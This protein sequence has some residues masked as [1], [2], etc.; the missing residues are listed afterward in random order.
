M[1]RPKHNAIS[2]GW[3]GSLHS[4]PAGG[5]RTRQGA[6]SGQSTIRN[7]RLGSRGRQG[8]AKGCEEQRSKSLAARK[9]HGGL[10]L[11]S[12]FRDSKTPLY[13]PRGGP[14]EGHPKGQVEGQTIDCTKSFS[15]PSDFRPRRSSLDI[16]LLSS[17]T[18]P[19]LDDS[20]GHVQGRVRCK[21]SGV[22]FYIFFPMTN[23]ANS[24]SNKPVKVFRLRGVSASVFENQ[25]EQNGTFHK[26]QIIRT[27][28]DGK[29]FKTTPTF[30]R[31]ELPIVN[32]LTQQ[33]WEYVLAE[34]A[35][36]RNSHD[37]D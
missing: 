19:P 15:Q 37:S 29:D 34:E 20:T 28:R 21:S 4:A 23:M 33:A 9:L 14:V 25:S 26:V 3:E 12:D 18:T 13:L 22:D 16:Q 6:C 10:R 36:Q 11:R 31:D 30:S 17:S 27:Y 5:T 24:S 2:N 7:M 8:V 32:L 35:S 1:L